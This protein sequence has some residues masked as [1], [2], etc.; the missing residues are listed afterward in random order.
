LCDDDIVGKL[1]HNFKSWQ[2]V[3]GND[4]DPLPWL[5]Q[6]GKGKANQRLATI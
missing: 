1:H 5:K 3:P 4:V 2:S 6:H